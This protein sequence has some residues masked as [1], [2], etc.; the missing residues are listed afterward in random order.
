MPP[1]CLLI[2]EGPAYL[3]PLLPGYPTTLPKGKSQ[4]ISFPSQKEKKQKKEGCL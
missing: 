1:G 3:M 4:D 2:P